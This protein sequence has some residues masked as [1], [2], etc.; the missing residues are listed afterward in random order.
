MTGFPVVC[1]FGKRPRNTKKCFPALEKS[2]NLIDLP[3]IWESP[4]ILFQ[5]TV[6]CEHCIPSAHHKLQFIDCFNHVGLLA[7]HVAESKAP[8]VW[9]LKKSILLTDTAIISKL[10]MKAHLLLVNCVDSGSQVMQCNENIQWLTI[11]WGARVDC[12]SQ[13]KIVGLVK[14]VRYVTTQNRYQC[15]ILRLLIMLQ[16]CNCCLFHPSWWFAVENSRSHS[17]GKSSFIVYPFP[18]WSRTKP[19]N[20]L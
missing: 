18:L 2:R 10:E 19:P 1:E 13:Y 7:A 8:E 9:T 14:F 11:V 12:S 16:V 20:R 3:K 17:H 4:W 6:F 15:H 5:A